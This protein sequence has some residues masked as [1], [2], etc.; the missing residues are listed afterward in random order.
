MIRD[1]VN[2]RINN[3]LRSSWALVVL[4]DWLSW[5]GSWLDD[6]ES[7]ES[8]YTKLSAE[9]LVGLFVAIDCCYLGETGKVLGCFFVGGLK[10]LAMAAP[11]GVEFDNLKGQ[12]TQV[13]S[14]RLRT[15]V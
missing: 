11:W 1:L 13:D 6:L 3:S 4:D 2:H 10:V 12:Q 5:L 15:E 9:R 8:L 7:R 14:Q